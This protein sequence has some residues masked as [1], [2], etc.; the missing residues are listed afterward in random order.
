MIVGFNA[1]GKLIWEQNFRA[2]D[3]VTEA[4]LGYRVETIL[5]K[6]TR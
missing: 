3:I 2:A 4:I 6:H 1:G 5:G